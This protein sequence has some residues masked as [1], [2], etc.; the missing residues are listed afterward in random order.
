MKAALFHAYNGPITIETVPDPT[1]PPGGVVIAVRA[2]GICRSDWH[3]WQGHDPD[4]PGM[5]H[6]PGHELAG[7]VVELAPDVK[8]WRIGDRVT[9]PFCLGCGVCPQCNTGNQQICDAYQQPG[10]TMWG[11]F[12]EYVA[13]PYANTN[14]VRIPEA[15]TYTEIAS[16][17]CRFVTAFRAVVAQ[18]R[19]RT[20]E[21]VSVYGC[22]GVGLSGV[23]I[24][25]A[26]GANVIAVDIN[27]AAL[28]LA[29][30]LGATHTVNASDRPQE[31]VVAEVREFAGGGVH[32]S[33]DALGSTVTCQNSI[34]SLR[35]RGR[36][37]QV[38]LLVGEHENPRLPMGPVISNELEIY[39]SHGMQAHAYPDL[40]TLMQRSKLNPS[41]LV[42]ARVHLNDA[43][44][45]LEGMGTYQTVGIT[46]I[47]DFA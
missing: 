5:P 1:P 45:V 42:T 25:A 26:S 23:M 21:W 2:T 4:I 43:P 27:P 34:L 38:G 12:A 18:G 33:L 20:G 6:I 39:G 36:H 7:D 17:G 47:D 31:H 37:V 32:L 3:G 15:M 10:F 46:V 28:D 41:A 30:S 8:N 16:L 40:L 14:L 44:A 19:L 11:S 29:A 9:V 13:L 22:G 35:K 24:A